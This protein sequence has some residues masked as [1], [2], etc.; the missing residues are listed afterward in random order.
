MNLR[1]RL[2]RLESDRQLDMQ[3][4]LHPDLWPLIGSRYTHED[5]IE[6]LAKEAAIKRTGNGN[7]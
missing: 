1:A 6:L 3:A 2:D 7:S 5:F 4:N